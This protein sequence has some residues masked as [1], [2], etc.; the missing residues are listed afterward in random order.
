MTLGA[1]NENMEPQSFLN[2]IKM[3]IQEEVSN[4]VHSIILFSMSFFPKIVFEQFL[5]DR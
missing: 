4:G 3:I 2:L 5:E 1:T